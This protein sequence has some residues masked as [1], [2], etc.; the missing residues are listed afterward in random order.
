[1]ITMQLLLMTLVVLVFAGG[2]MVVDA[3]K[4]RF[5]LAKL[6]TDKNG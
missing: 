2:P 5:V 6:N 3:I 1:M 4:D